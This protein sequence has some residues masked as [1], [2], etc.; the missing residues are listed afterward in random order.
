MATIKHAK[1]AKRPAAKR[2]KKTAAKRFLKKVLGTDA[3]RELDFRQVER[4][5][6]DEWRKAKLFEA[7][8]DKKRPSFMVTV[9]YPY[10]NGA[11]HIGAGFTFIRG[12][13][14]AR[15]K[16]MRGFNV[17][18]GQGFHATGEPIVGAVKRLREG[19]KSQVDTFKIYGISDADIR[20]FADKGPEYVAKF[21]KARWIEDL[22]A[23]GFSVD[24]RRT[25]ITTTMT[26]TYS[27]FVEW[28]YNTLKKRDYV[29]QGTHPVVWCPSCQS[30]TGDHDRLDGV[31]ESVLEYTVIKFKLATGEI[32]PCATLRP[33]TVYG[34]T[35]IWIN[36]DAEYVRA[37]V[38]G[39]KWIVGAAAV[40]KL[41]DQLKKV[42]VLGIVMGAEL[43]GKSCDNPVTKQKLPVLPASLCDTDVATGVVMSVPSHA[44]YDWIGLQ[45]LK[46]DKRTLQRYGIES[47]VRDVEPISIIA[48]EG[49]GEHPAKDACERFGVQSQADVDKLE[50]AT[51]LLYKKEFHTGVLKSN[52]G[53]YA[54]MKVTDAKQ[55]I[56][57][58]LVEQ[59]AAASMWETTASVVCR[60]K[61][62]C[63]VKILENQWFLKFSD[64]SWKARAK[65]C[66][67]RMAFYPEDA[68]QQF[69]NTVDWLEDK[70]CTR[71]SGMGTPLPWD[72]SWIVETLSDS[73]IYMAYY[74][75]ARIINEKGVR[76]EQ[77][78]DEVFDYIFFGTGDPAKL[79]KASGLDKT[80]IAA[81]HE[82]FEYFYPV[83][84]R[85]SGK[86][87][88]QNHLTFFIFH[89]VAIWDKPGLDKFWPRS[90]GVNGYVNVGGE[91]MSKSKGNFIPL[92]DLLV[93]HGADLVRINIAASNENMDDADWREDSIPTYD[94]RLNYMFTL[95]ARLKEAKR[96]AEKP[97]DRYLE[98]KTNEIIK[99][100]TEHYEHTRFRSA[101]QYG[102]FAM[103]NEMK[104][105]IERVGGMK[106]ANRKA[107][108]AAFETCV[109]LVAPL[110]PHAAEEL[111]HAIGRKTF[112]STESWPVADEKK[113]DRNALQM[114]GMYRKTV[115]DVKAVAKLAGKEDMS[116]TKLYLFF[117]TDK[118]LDY[119]KES[120]DSLKAALGPKKLE[121][122][123]AGA[124]KIYDPQDRAKRAKF[125]RPAIYLE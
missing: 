11:P 60:C 35:N 122:F 104:S 30:P 123:K 113:I 5:W 71:R 92:R 10:V 62:R 19:D 53:P 101:T 89:H 76:A 70:A 85:N 77:L 111:W 63:H 45:D 46:K 74:T 52:C 69:E 67:K 1:R 110:V 13:V 57:K 65:E 39:E 47:T 17:L 118:E 90:I 72:R 6:Q 49:F 102:L 93:K 32:L 124:S 29:T 107:L 21:W 16:R 78:T 97:I 88:V 120:A 109:K 43:I 27:R 7:N 34:V 33:E 84:F 99:T 116:A 51:N 121:M 8:V 50:K 41:E 25:F 54:G 59:D 96:T 86:D 40:R 87:L 4:K 64:P 66:I 91:K 114:E 37:E 105:Y 20:A 125:G 115:D 106:F 83:G 26:P 119:F 80:I 36:P 95:A 22:T 31:G 112:V 117:A 2:A 68:R 12:D 18:F 42:K 48:T 14:Y 98:S 24:W 108:E 75:L 103:T 44:P 38:D 100:A 79:A 23:T 73:T 94:S 28:Q 61:T 55:R 15:Y 81:L 82:E 56:M 58:H 9:P 3:V